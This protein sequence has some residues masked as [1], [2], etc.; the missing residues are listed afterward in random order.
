MF[1]VLCCKT[2]L[3]IH[4]ERVDTE[5]PSPFFTNIFA[6]LREQ[7]SLDSKG[8]KVSVYCHHQ[9]YTPVYAIFLLYWAWVVRLGVVA[10]TLGWFKLRELPYSTREKFFKKYFFF[11]KVV[12]IKPCIQE[13]IRIRQLFWPSR[14]KKTFKECQIWNTLIYSA[15]NIRVTTEKN[16]HVWDRFWCWATKPCDARELRNKVRKKSTECKRILWRKFY[17]CCLC[18]VSLVMKKEIFQI[19]LYSKISETSIGGNP[20]LQYVKL[21]LFLLIS[22]P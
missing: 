5:E 14:K 15:C 8:A 22:K 17:H 13:I 11:W 3:F 7:T 12:E 19:F 2:A 10:C 9:P 16:T 18:L 4:Q 1:T 20:I 21:E 6:L